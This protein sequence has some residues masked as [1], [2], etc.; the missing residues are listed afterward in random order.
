MLT[1]PLSLTARLEQA[2]AR[3][4]ADCKPLDA[5]YPA[6]AV[7]LSVSDGGQRAHVTHACEENFD[8]AWGQACMQLGELVERHKLKGRWL[9]ID[10]VESAKPISMSALD[11][12]LRNTKRNYFRHGLA[13]D[14][15]LTQA[16]TE[17][18][19]NAN[20]MLYAG[21]SIPHA[22]FNPKNFA[23][24]AQRRHGASARLPAQPDETLHLLALQGVFI[25]EEGELLALGGPGPDAGRRALTLTPETTLARVEQG[26]NYLATQVREDGR[27]I[28]GWFPCFD[29]EIASYNT[30]RHASSTYAMLEA[31]ELTRDDALLQAIERA[32][33]HLVSTLIRPYTLADGRQLAFLIDTGDE[34]KLGGNAVCLLALVKH[35][36]L[37]GSDR[38][39][40]VMERLALGIAYM[41]HA[42]SGRFD[43]VLNAS[44][45][46]V[47]AAFRIIYY[48]GEA[49]FGLMR[50]HGLTRDARWLAIVEK[51]FEHFIAAEHWRAHDHWLS[52]CVNELTRH[53]PLEQYFRFGIRN[54]AD[55]LDFVLERET[56]FPTL[57]ELML[58]AEQMLNR[59]NETPS[60]R[61]L[62]ADIDIGKFYRALDFRAHHLL[63]G[64][65]WPELAMYFRNPARILGSFFIRHHGFRVRID[66]VEH[67][68]SGFVAYHAFLMR[69]GT[70]QA[71]ADLQQTTQT[72]KHARQTRTASPR[73][74]GMPNWR[75][76]DVLAATGGRWA[77]PPQSPRW[78]ATGLCIWLPSLRAGQMIALRPSTGKGGVPPSVLP[79]A[80]FLPQAV[81]AS[82]PALDLVP[83]PIPVLEVPDLNRAILDLG[84]FARRH[85]RGRI[86]GITGS[87]G[88]TTTVAMLA[89][90]LRPWGEVGQT[91][92]NANLP[93]GIAWNLASIPWDVP[94]IV[95]E[96]AIGRMQQNA[97]LVRPHVGVVTN[98]AAA[99]LEHH[100]TTAEVARRKSRIFSAMDDDGVAVLNRDMA[101]WE[102]VHEAA[103]RRG[104]R[105]IH[106]GQG[107][108]CDVRLLQYES[109]SGEILIHA[110]GRNHRYC[111]GAPGRH[112]AY[113][114][115][116]C[117][118]VALALDLPLEPLLLQFGDFQ[119]V[120][121]RGATH[122]LQI[123]PRRLRI[124]DEAYNA[125]PVSMRAAIEL[126]RELSPPR[127]D[128]RRILVLGDMLE[129]GPTSEQLHQALWPVI[130]D[131]AADLLVL[132][133]QHMRSLFDMARQHIAS[134]W[135]ETPEALNEALIDLLRDGDLVLIKSSGGTGLSRSVDLLKRAASA[136]ES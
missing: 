75:A 68:L 130:S 19:L 11:E 79:Q 82:E 54:I 123:G 70:S 69:G 77:R 121:G 35:S 18:E 6:Y 48:D 114:S 133:G 78:Q 42:D 23:V 120:D 91:A 89:R 30:L 15:G 99:H 93:H 46:S 37:T 4:A 39:M 13:L 102:I 118:A 55:Y 58:A 132:C 100:G 12:R 2:R 9:R 32:L 125:N 57:L 105:V 63:N 74:P 84:R 50:L 71:L 51:A 27:F 107:R 122:D 104:L 109:A 119:P 45:L 22:Q 106:Y 90:A 92:H 66:D 49:A 16:Y 44:D 76:D 112:M 40:Q 135:F 28:Y 97:E 131:A 64:H 127:P 116:A 110:G 29:R 111:L 59:L 53:R 31:W 14:K 33:D 56:T 129:L 113:N 21:S 108:D 126:A 17:L 101:E 47:K 88:K 36:E 81:I 73:V 94:H 41:Q 43:H 3:V 128:G 115:L 5:P 134:A 72:L 96:M 136:D 10:W 67:Y 52:Y 117:V 7:F 103:C 98:I 24:Y 38:H 86:I 65:F 87:A 34:I 85:I 26:A 95:M 1:L 61:D 8:Q 60:V 83:A 25:T 62:L 80:P 20:A 124:L